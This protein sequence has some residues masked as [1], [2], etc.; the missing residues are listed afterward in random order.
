[1][2]SIALSFFLSFIIS[3]TISFIISF[4]NV[5]NFHDAP[6][7]FLFS[8]MTTSSLTGITSAFSSILVILLYFFSLLNITA[9][10]FRDIGLPGWTTAILSFFPGVMAAILDNSILSI[11]FT[12]ISVIIIF[13]P[14]IVPTNLFSNK[15]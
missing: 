12:C 11:F 5:G 9:K 10:R 14:F 3:F 8:E 1:M 2:F 4:M 15:E 7:I 13:L 6:T